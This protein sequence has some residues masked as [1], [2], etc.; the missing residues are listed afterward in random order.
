M[1]NDV[2]NSTNTQKAIRDLPTDMSE[3][4]PPDMMTEV[5]SIYMLV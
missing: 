3:R 1:I 5:V 2:F 4:M